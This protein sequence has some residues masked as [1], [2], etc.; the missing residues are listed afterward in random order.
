MQTFEYYCAL[1]PV[2]TT[3]SI[4]INNIKQITLN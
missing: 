1:F 3:Y 4:N 2:E